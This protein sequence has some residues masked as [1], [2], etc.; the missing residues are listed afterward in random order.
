MKITKYQCI[1]YI[2]VRGCAMSSPCRQRSC[3]HPKD[4]HKCVYIRDRLSLNVSYSSL[5]GHRVSPV[6]GSIIMLSASAYS[7]MSMSSDMI[8]PFRRNVL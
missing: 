1:S 4:V 2:A 3:C 8:F 7:C 6:G 5:L